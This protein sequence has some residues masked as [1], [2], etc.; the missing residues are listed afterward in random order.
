MHRNKRHLYSIT[1]SAG[2]SSRGISSP[3]AFAVFT[4]VGMV[5]DGA[6]IFR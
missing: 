2:A 6:H 1:S 3:S 4:L 5:E